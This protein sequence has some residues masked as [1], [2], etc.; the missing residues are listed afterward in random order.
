MAKWLH[1]MM[2]AQEKTVRCQALPVPGVSSELEIA[3]ERRYSEHILSSSMGRGKLI[4][5]NPTAT[6]PKPVTSPPRLT[7]AGR[8]DVLKLH[9]KRATQGE[10]W[11]YV[12]PKD[13]GPDVGCPYQTPKEA[14]KLQESE[15]VAQ[16][17]HSPLTSKLLAL[18]K[19]VIGDL[20]YEDVEEADLGCPDPEII[21]AVAHIPQADAWADVVMQESHSPPGFEPEVSR[22]GYDVNLVHTNPTEPGSASPVMVGEDKMLDEANSRTPGAG[23]PGTDENPGCTEDN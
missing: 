18:G 12:E 9:L 20:D 15:Q 13:S 23:W 21:Q 1:G 6:S 10:G 3:L 14:N 17:G 19:E 8:G 5:E 2:A 11:S 16:P 22:S 7:K 4:A